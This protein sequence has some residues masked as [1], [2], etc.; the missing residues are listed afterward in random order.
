[1]LYIH[2]CPNG[3]ASWVGPALQAGGGGEY[4]IQRLTSVE[5]A[6]ARLAGGGV[7]GVLLDVTGEDA[8]APGDLRRQLDERA[9]GIVVAALVPDRYE[10]NGFSAPVLREADAAELPGILRGRAAAET[11][12]PSAV[13]RGS[14]HVV[15]FVGVKGGVGTTTTAINVAAALTARGPVALAE[16]Y[17][18]WGGLHDRLASY[19]KTS[20][21]TPLLTAD[22]AA[23]HPTSVEEAL[24]ESQ[25]RPLL[26]VLSV[27]PLAGA[28][29][30][31]D[32]PRTDRLVASLTRCSPWTILDVSRG[33]GEATERALLGADMV[34]AVGELTPLAVN[35]TGI[36]INRLLQ[37]GVSPRK[38]ACVLVNRVPIP[39]PEP[40]EDVRKKIPAPLLQVIPPA[41]EVC[42][43]AEKSGGSTIG[44][45]PDD[46]ASES[47]E[48]IAAEA[49]KRLV[50]MG[51]R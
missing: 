3:S 48:V 26:R 5:T 29:V 1:M 39:N 47:Y 18:G 7:S 4:R 19:A 6:L 49:F 46:L 27:P 20:G 44:L 38:L 45:R 10:P 37:W 14:G 8:P 21:M 12:A 41:A 43:L 22:L 23:I 51:A 13:L 25:E 15:A 11:A 2:L 40:I 24:W 35:A 31:L 30:T 9:E 50:T 42:G 17:S 34:I 32:A 36:A 16:I 28:E 33:E